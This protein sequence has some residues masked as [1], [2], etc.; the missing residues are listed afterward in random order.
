MSPM[1]DFL[2]GTR[3]L[4]ILVETEISI[5]AEISIEILYQGKEDILV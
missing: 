4:C 1:S 2:A 3:K 5:D